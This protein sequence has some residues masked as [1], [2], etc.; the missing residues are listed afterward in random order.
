MYENGREVSKNE[1]KAI[2]WYQKAAEQGHE[3]ALECL[4]SVTDRANANDQYNLGMMFYNGE[5]APQ[6]YKKAA[7]WFQKSAE[8]GYADAQCDLGWMYYNGEGVA[9]DYKKAAEWY[10]KAADQEMQ[11]RSISLGGCITTVKA[12]PKTIQKQ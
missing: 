1:E 3:E 4:Q 10:Q 5:G 7:E 11:T 8:Q 6:D 12:F 9:R 2:E